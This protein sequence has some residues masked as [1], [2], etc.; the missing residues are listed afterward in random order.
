MWVEKLLEFGG[1]EG[2]GGQGKQES[3]GELR[4]AGL[5]PFQRAGPGSQGPGVSDAGREGAGEV[6][7]RPGLPREQSWGGDS[8]GIVLGPRWLAVGGASLYSQEV[9]RSQVREVTEGAQGWGP[10]GSALPRSPS[11]LSAPSLP[12]RLGPGRGRLLARRDRGAGSCP[13]R[14]MAGGGDRATAPGSGRGRE[15]GA[16]G[17]SDWSSAGVR[18]CSL[19]G[20]LARSAPPPDPPPPPPPPLRSAPA[21]PLRPRPSAPPSPYSSEP[22]GTHFCRPPHPAGRAQSPAWAS[23]PNF[24]SPLSP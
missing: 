22:L 16:A 11:P 9:G 3:G 20:W 19:L 2:A 12:G 10:A 24:T 7:S 17:G 5:G 21:P 6:R 8:S 23:K 15:R 13:R 4:G 18:R 1:D 14:R